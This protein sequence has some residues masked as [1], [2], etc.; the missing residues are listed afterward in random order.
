VIAVIAF[1]SPYR[2]GAEREASRLAEEAQARLPA[3][4]QAAAHLPEAVR[5]RVAVEAGR[6]LAQGAE[7]AL[8]GPLPPIATR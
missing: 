3:P 6:A 5:E 4:A 2:G 8:R 7:A 1:L